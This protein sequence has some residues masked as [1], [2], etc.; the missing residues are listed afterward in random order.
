MKGYSFNIMSQKRMYTHHNKCMV[1]GTHFSYENHSMNNMRKFCSHECRR[2]QS[3]ISAKERLN[4]IEM[5]E[6]FNSLLLSQGGSCALCPETKGLIRDY[7]DNGEP[8]GLLCPACSR[9]LKLV[10]DKLLRLGEYLN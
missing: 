5:D 2:K 3:K 4:R 10:G 6:R 8:K 9:G 1:C 7:D